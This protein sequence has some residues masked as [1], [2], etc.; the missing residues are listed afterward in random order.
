MWWVHCYP[1]IDVGRT[2][3]QFPFLTLEQAK[4]P[5]GRYEA[6]VVRWFYGPSDIVIV[7]RGE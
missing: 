3:S 7:E 5:D 2:T 1:T 6:I 4:S